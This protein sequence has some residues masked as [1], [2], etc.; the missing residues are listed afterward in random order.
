MLRQRPPLPV[1]LLY[2]DGHFIASNK[3]EAFAMLDRE[4]TEL[5]KKI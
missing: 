1:A 2:G 3:K 5:V 4:V